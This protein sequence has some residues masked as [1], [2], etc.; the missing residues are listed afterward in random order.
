MYLTLTVLSPRLEFSRVAEQ[1]FWTTAETGPGFGFVEGGLEGGGVG[2][3]EAEGADALSCG[4]S[5]DVG[6]AILSA[7]QDTQMKTSPTARYTAANH[8]RNLIVFLLFPLRLHQLRLLAL[9]AIGR[10]RV[11]SVDNCLLALRFISSDLLINY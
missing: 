3:F 11:E 7:L 4:S 8:R 9:L 5:S 6:P 1:S 2:S 10:E